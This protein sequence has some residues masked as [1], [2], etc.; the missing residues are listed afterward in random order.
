MAKV[1]AKFCL[2]SRVFWSFCVCIIIGTVT[3]VSS[4]QKVPLSDER[5]VDSGSQPGG[6]KRFWVESKIEL[7]RF[8]NESNSCR[9]ANE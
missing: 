3:E 9:A 1:S 2:N 4:T 8:I 6:I 7:K 5:A